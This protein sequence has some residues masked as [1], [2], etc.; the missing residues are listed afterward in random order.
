MQE[1]KSMVATTEKKDEGDYLQQ[2]LG[3]VTTVATRVAHSL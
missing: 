1:K 3:E 2:S